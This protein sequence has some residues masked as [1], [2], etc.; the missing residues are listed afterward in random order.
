MY[1][2]DL[3]CQKLD[4]KC[5][6]LDFESKKLD[7][8]GQKTRFFG[9]LLEWIQVHLR[10]KKACKAN[11]RHQAAKKSIGKQ[12]LLLRQHE[13]VEPLIFSKTELFFILVPREKH[14]EFDALR[15]ATRQHFP[16]YTLFH[17]GTIRQLCNPM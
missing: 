11:K 4:L 5:K 9:I 13:T 2:L 7:F 17:L 10:G 3:K 16:I 6:K 1:K 8:K 14:G 15:N 12:A